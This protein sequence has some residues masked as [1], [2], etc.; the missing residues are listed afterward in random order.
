MKTNRSARRIVRIRGIAICLAL[1]GMV[2]IAF[3]LG[4]S[5][6]VRVGQTT[7]QQTEVPQAP[8]GSLADLI[9]AAQ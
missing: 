2:G 1:G 6:A 5:L 7:T 3:S 4:E 8:N 9:A